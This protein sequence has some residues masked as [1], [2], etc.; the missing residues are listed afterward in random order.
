V[1][2]IIMGGV[3]MKEKPI[4]MF[5]DSKFYVLIVESSFINICDSFD[6]Y[7]PSPPNVVVHVFANSQANKNKFFGWKCRL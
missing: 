5:H 2:N 1:A 4:A 7:S 3:L 6:K